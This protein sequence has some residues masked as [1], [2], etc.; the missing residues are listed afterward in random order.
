M[1]IKS[2][3]KFGSYFTADFGMSDRASYQP[4]SYKKECRF[5][6]T[7][8]TKHLASNTNSRDRPP[9]FVKSRKFLQAKPTTNKVGLT[10]GVHH[11]SIH[12]AELQWR[13]NIDP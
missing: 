7:T 12:S 13:R 4:V 5:P 10:K 1:P 9:N 8:E 3:L 2:F 6:K 11:V